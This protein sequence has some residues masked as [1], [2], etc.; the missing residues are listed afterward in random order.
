MMQKPAV[1]TSGALGREGK[2][3]ALRL[4]KNFYDEQI[5]TLLVKEFY[6]SDIAVSE[7]AIAASGSLGNEVAIKHLYQIIERGRK[8]QRIAAIQALAGIRAPSSVEMLIKYFNHFPEEEVRSEILRAINMIAPSGLQVLELNQAVYSNQKQAD[9]VRQV[10]SESL[11]ETEKF[12][13]LKGTL[14]K[15]SPGVQQAA[16]V[17]MLQSGSQE[18]FDLDEKTLSPVALGTY[19]CLQ[20]L[21]AKNLQ[22]NAVLETLQSSPR[23][24]VHSF[25]TCLSQFQGR[26][27]FPTRVFRML[28]ICPYVDWETE[29]LIGDFLK[30]V[31]VEV[32]E[33]SPHLLSE[34][35]VVT[36]AHLD[37]VFAK[38]RKNYISLQGIT[39]KQVLLAT[40]LATLLENYATTTLLADVIAFFKDDGTARTPPVAQVRSLLSSAPKEDLNRFEACIPLFAYTEIKD[41]MLVLAQLSKVELSRPFYLR[42]LNRLIRVAG[43]L[44]IRSASKRIQDIL[45]FARSERIHFLEETSVVTLCQLLTRFI[46][47]QS[48]E[49]FKEPNKNIRSLNGYIR[50]AR[51]IPP[52][53]LIGPLTQ[54]LMVP[55][56]NPRS[57][58][59]VV[60]TLESMEDG[61]ARRTG[62][63]ESKKLL[64]PLLKV[65]DVK[66]VDDVLKLRVV[67]I[68]CRNIDPSI[69]HQAMDLTA[70]PTPTGRKAG[71]R[72]LKAVSAQ[73]EGTISDEVT[74]RLYRLLEDADKSVRVESLLALLAIED[75]YAAQ[76]LKDFVVAKDSPVVADVL[77]A[78]SKP[79]SREAFAIVL[80][81]IWLEDISVQEALRKLLPEL[82]QGGFA[83]EIRQQLVAALT[84]VPE[85]Q[86]QVDTAV[87]PTA[88]PLESTLDQDK[89]E[90]KFKREH[91][92]ILTVF[93][94]DIAGYTEKSTQVDT[95]ILLKIIKA[96]EEIVTSAIAANRGAIVKKM[97]DGILAVFKHPLYAT[98][99]ALEVQQK[100]RDHSAVRVEQEKFQARVGLNTGRIIRRENDIF[101]EVVNVASRMQGV[102]DKGEVVLTQATFDEIKEYVRCTTGGKVQVKGIKEPIMVYFAKEVTADLSAVKDSSSDQSNEKG[103]LRDPSLQKL[104]ESMFVPSFQAPPGK[105]EHAKLMSQLETVFSDLSQFVEK[106]AMDY[107]EEYDFKKYL[108]DR[109]NILLERL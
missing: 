31:V 70:H 35:S 52:R 46:I 45:D 39:N 107:R 13:L 27:R 84:L 53:I 75:D 33:A 44:E 14:P 85:G 41:R 102:A 71:I 88:P 66:E 95:S 37:N 90:F 24:T 1:S 105:N 17:K 34:F 26:L 60:E 23:P 36:S 20:T 16:L 97:G 87:T 86:S 103:A 68:L 48:R 89:I 61:G 94:I 55:S 25:L 5:F 67:D 47:E 6:N 7:A 77:S 15:A 2:I 62:L 81:C 9:V 96:F 51:F 108:Q 101:G 74:G 73:S 50:G 54:V 43:A 63:S 28:L 106:V 11:V 80:D 92:Q 76:V 3:T 49:Y 18:I 82:S 19:L 91:T 4:L 65:L 99:A 72:L 30:K 83:E 29:A 69:G 64:T 12:A 32:K 57:R 8:T 38:V 109:W 10:A 58:A 104:K 56:L 93:F 100:I 42:R 78:L 40:L 98:V 79:L 59:L 21:K 22:A